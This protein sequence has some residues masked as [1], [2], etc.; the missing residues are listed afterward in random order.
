[1]FSVV[2]IA[3][4]Y[5]HCVLYVFY[6]LV[7]VRSFVGSGRRVFDEYR[8]CLYAYKESLAVY[9]ITAAQCTTCI[10]LQQCSMY[11]YMFRLHAHVHVHGSRWGDGICGALVQFGCYQHRY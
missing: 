11:M 1:M 4:Q 2:H 8:D 5:N 3:S 7:G 9:T 6:F 10:V